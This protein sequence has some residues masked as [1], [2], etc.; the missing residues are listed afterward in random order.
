[1]IPI[2]ELNKV[3]KTVLK[4]FPTFPHF[5]SGFSPAQLL[6]NYSEINT[7]EESVVK[8]RVT[9]EDIN[10]IYNDAEMPAVKYIT[11]WLDFLNRFSNINKHLTE[12]RAVAFMIFKDYKHFYLSDLKIIFEK[13]MRGEYG[14]FYGSVDA[15]RILIGFMQ[16]KI[17]RDIVT[18]RNKASL[19]N[20]LE[21]F[22]DKIKSDVQ[23]EV[24]AIMKEKYKDLP[25]DEYFAKRHE[26]MNGMLPQAIK[27]AREK[28]ITEYENKNK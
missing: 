3:Q 8:R 5:L 17:E 25:D 10:I 4:N 12:T 2:T 1:M 24:F 23:S 14:P 26:L 28:F 20:E 22:L 7:I 9:I 6:V 27:E 19:Q 15:Q 13:L 16:Y 21:S 18:R 11:E